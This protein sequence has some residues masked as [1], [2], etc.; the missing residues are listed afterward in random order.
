MNNNLRLVLL[1]E[2]DKICMILVGVRVT[3]AYSALIELPVS[4]LIQFS[5]CACACPKVFF[6]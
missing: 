2:L 1:Q 3:A 4:V 5:V 6:G